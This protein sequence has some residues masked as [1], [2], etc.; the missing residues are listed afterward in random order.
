MNP[1][2]VLVV[3]DMFLPQRSPDINEQF[4][5]ILTP[6]KVQHVLCLGNIG[7][8][9]TYDWLKSLSKDFHIVKGD[10]DQ[11][12]IPEKK[13]IQ[14]GDFN[15]GLIH[16]HQVLPWGD[17]DSL[18]MIQRTM[19]CDILI[20][21]HTH[22]TNVV[23]KDNIL[24]INPG[25]FTG[26]FSPLI[27]DTIPSFI[28]MVLTGDEAI[29]YLYTLNDRNKKFEVN[30]YD[31]KKGADNLFHVENEEEEEKKDDEDDL[32]RKDEE[33]QQEQEQEEEMKQ[34]EEQG[35]EQNELKDDA[36]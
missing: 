16:G 1:E 26:A 7:N 8:Q 28:L 9:E 23:V 20:S 5:S 27:E 24:Y 15:I 3:G 29:V 19:G 17:I 2:L 32:D 13:T 31:Y 6:N 30:K 12:D 34:Q 10:F 21:G 4:K 14:I 11:E 22:K 18:G 36:E 33:P 35:Q 25:S